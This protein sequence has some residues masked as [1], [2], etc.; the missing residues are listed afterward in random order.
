M[1]K[2]TEL[3]LHP[4]TGV[5]ALWVS[6]TGR[7]FYPIAGGDA[8]GDAEPGRIE[9]L[10]AELGALRTEIDELDA[11]DAPTDEQV[12]R[13]GVAL[14][15]WDERHA[16][17]ERLVERRERIARVRSAAAH[18][19]NRERTAPEVLNRRDPFENLD[20]LRFNPDD[21]YAPRM[22]Q[23]V[24]ARA[25]TALEQTRPSGISDA[26]ME[27]AVRVVETIP[28]AAQHALIHGSPAYRSAFEAWLQSQG[29]PIYT[30]E[31]AE[32][33]RA[34]MSLSGGNGGYT[35]PT[36]LDPTLI[37]TGTASNNPI[38]PIA[39][40]VQGTQNVWHGVSVGNVT[41]YWAAEAA[42][43]TEGSPAFSNPSVT[44]AK[45]TAWLTASYEI[46]EDSNLQAQMPGLIAE[47]F[48]YTESDAFVSGSGSNAPKG[49]LTA[50]SGTAGDTVTCTTRGTFGYVDLTNLHDAAPARYED[51]STFLAN[52]S[53]YTAIRAFATGSYGSLFWANLGQ[54]TPPQLI[55][56]PY[57]K[58][59]AMTNSTASG[60]KFMIYGDFSQFLIYDRIGTQVE[61]VQNVMN[62]SG[63][64]TG[65]RGLVAHKR[66]GSDV[67]DL[68]AFRFLLG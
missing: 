56:S 16:E 8:S 59:S 26:E 43:L 28:G 50:I 55:D 42:A 66:V 60:S 68:N 58:A 7:P 30:P 61:F 47:S 39:R 57:V 36:L 33:V 62:S 20:A 52:K 45:L 44:A 17:H 49:I 65:Q 23:D 21:R 64:P 12:T 1:S 63:L 35:L 31:Q 3:P 32:A 54:D 10:E 41:S 2:P 38:R 22:S 29:Q 15:E 24:V 46:F 37:H 34:A 6:P 18:P 13:M 9:E 19:A 40:V 14:D 5:R 27:R 53:I 48:M 51:S 4:F 25:V 67:T 11:L